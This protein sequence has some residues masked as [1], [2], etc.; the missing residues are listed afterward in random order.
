[1]IRAKLRLGPRRDGK[2]VDLNEM[3]VEYDTPEQF[4]A[5]RQGLNLAESFENV[6]VV[7]ESVEREPKE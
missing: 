6:W 2:P 3:D 7:E 5:F 4:A 1:M